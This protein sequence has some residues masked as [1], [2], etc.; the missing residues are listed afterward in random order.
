M[1][2]Q[3]EQAT[4]FH[5]ETLYYTYFIEFFPKRN[6]I[7]AKTFIDLYSKEGLS[8][9]Q[10]ANK[11]NIS[12]SSCVRILNNTRIQKR[13]SKELK[14]PRNYQFGHPPY[15]YKISINREL[16]INKTEIKICR[17]VV[18]LKN[19]GLSF[20]KVGEELENKEFKNRKGHIKWHNY[21]INNIY[22]RW[23][24]KL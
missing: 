18:N 4:S 15:G 24:D 1:V 9:S 21:T 12:K 19:K 2:D 10:I 3:P 6:L 16:I 14:N 8:I 23:K 13:T 7:K 5:D 22:S 11:L 17:L 20:K